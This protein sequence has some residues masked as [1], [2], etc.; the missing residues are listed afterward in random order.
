MDLAKKIS[1]V[2]LV[3]LDFETTGLDALTG[4]SI[5][6]IGAVKI[7]DRKVI[8]KFHTLI[9]PQKDIPH[10]AFLIHKISNDDVKDA[11]LFKDIADKLLMFF[12]DTVIC[13]YN[14]EFDIGFLNA[15]LKRIDKV[16][17]GCLV[18]DILSMARRTVKLGRYNL[19][20][21]SSFFNIEN[22]GD[23]HRALADAFLA[24][25]VFYKLT[26][27]LATK[28]IDNLE[29]FMALYGING[30]NRKCEEDKVNLVKAV[31]DKGLTINVRY[32]SLEQN[33]KNEEIKPQCVLE[34]N[35]KFYLWYQD[36]YQNTHR[37]SFRDI[38]NITIK[39]I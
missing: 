8:D 22:K 5:C 20:N 4:D 39:N 37:L 11:P 9:N 12:K 13:A 24:Y 27:I 6:E 14:A 7:R 10:G 15:E 1:D 31:I 38:L 35:K 16:C 32:F 3:F 21:L 26:D 23:L 30:Q 28:G 29:D 17:Q 34:E 25:E 2:D 19:G 18:I 36:P 33:I